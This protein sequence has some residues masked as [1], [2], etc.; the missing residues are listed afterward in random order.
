MATIADNPIHVT[1]N[2]IG[3]TT[4]DYWVYS[5]PDILARVLFT[6]GKSRLVVQDGS[7][8]HPWMTTLV[9]DVATEAEARA[10]AVGYFYRMSRDD[11]D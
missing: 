11:N 4:G 6:P 8:I 3:C 7:F 1:A 2:R 10:F 9:L 5:P